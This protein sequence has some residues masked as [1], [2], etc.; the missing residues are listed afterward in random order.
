MRNESSV[1]GTR[2][3]CV[4]ISHSGKGRKGCWSAG[5]FSAKPVIDNN[6]CQKCVRDI[7]PL[8]IHYERS[9]TVITDGRAVTV[10]W[11]VRRNSLRRIT[12]GVSSERWFG[13]TA[14]QKSS[15][16]AAYIYQDQRFEGQDEFLRENVAG[17]PAGRRCLRKTNDFRRITVSSAW[18]RFAYVP[19]RDT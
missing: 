1:R 3:I 18:T 2:I 9:R 4:S 13:R 14:K 12:P 8:L 5:A 10:I 11:A 7:A 19:I 15:G 17:G 6:E 16:L